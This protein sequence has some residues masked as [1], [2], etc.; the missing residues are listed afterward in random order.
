[1]VKFAPDGK[2]L[3]SAAEDGVRLW[4]PA[5]N[6]LLLH[7][8]LPQFAGTALA[9]SP[10]GKVLA[11]AGENQAIR[12]WDIAAAKELRRWDSHLDDVYLLVFAADGQSL[13]GL[14]RDAVQV[15][16]AAT[17]KEVSRYSGTDRFL[18][19]DVSPSG[20]VL[21]LAEF[22]RPQLP[23]GGFQE[24]FTIRLVEAHSGQ[25]ISHF[26][27][28]QGLVYTLAF[29]PDGRS[30]VSG[31]GDA[32]LLY[33]DLTGRLQG[34]TPQ[35]P[36]TVV[37]LAGLWSDL[38][39]KAAQ[40]DRAIWT[41]AQAPQQSVPFLG[42]R[43]QPAAPADAQQVAKLIADL[44][45]KNYALRQAATRGLEDLG[46]AAEAALYKLLADN[47]SLELR[48]RLEEILVKRNAEM[49]RQLRAIEALE[50]CGTAAARQVLQTLARLTPNPRLA[51]AAAAA[52][53][54]LARRNLSGSSAHQP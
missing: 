54:R 10:D 33:W 13:V 21:A 45:G 37:E 51:Q 2:L 11:F 16:A 44:D 41:L 12:L 9:F 26:E 29:T 40:A 49:V 17:G 1:V 8:P 22:A 28:P 24:G 23:D 36:L 53:E 39:G 15:W 43:L 47:P 46:A 31:G 27:V 20:R 14:T 6:K 38:G 52:L 19:L 25:E 42:K 34:T 50:H 32:T 30:L 3:A 7:L 48:R 4:D 5:A 35:G 18:T